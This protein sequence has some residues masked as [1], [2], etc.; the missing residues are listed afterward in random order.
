MR[1]DII[2]EDTTLRDGEQSPGVAFSKQTKIAIF[3]AL[4]EAGVRWI[5]IGIPA[6]GGQ[7][8]ETIKTLIAR[9]SHDAMLVGWNRGVLEDVKQSIELGFKAIHIGL[10]TSHIHLKESVKKDRHWLLRQAKDLVMYA[11]DK[12]VF[13]SISAEDVGRS[14]I[15]FIQEYAAHVEEAGADRLRLSDTIGILPPEKYSDIIKKIRQVSKID[16]QCHAHNDF[17]F[18]TANTIAGLNAGARYFHVT[19]NG[20]GERAGMPDLAQVVMALKELYNINLGI[21]LD[22]LIELSRIVQSAT[23]VKCPP[24][25]PIVGENVFAHESGIHVSGTIR[26]QST[27]EPFPPELVAGKRKIII[28]KHSGRAAIKYILE[29]NNISAN[30]NEL[31]LCLH[32]VR[33]LS[34]NQQRSLTDIELVDLYHKVTIQEEAVNAIS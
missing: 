12:D 24:W 31:T 21:K 26:N 33:E 3:D 27:F 20:I 29:K 15:A 19:V 2:L 6:M 32:H 17:G 13:V 5:E 14:E 4:M 10:P 9:N 22:Q 18:A 25:Q 1:N 11:K 30:D 8:L 16:L 23:K 7:E 28:G 34:M